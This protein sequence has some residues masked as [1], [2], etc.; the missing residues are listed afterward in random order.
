VSA[1]TPEHESQKQAIYD[2]MSPRRR[3][4]VDRIGYDKWDPFQEPKDPIE[5]RRDPTQRTA[6]GLATEFLRSRPEHQ[7]YDT[8]YAAA[9]QEAAIGVIRGDDQVRAV[10]EFYTWYLHLLEKEGIKE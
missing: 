5:I 1:N 3:K 8:P 7:G 6:Q 9:V 10:Y 4:F 2:R